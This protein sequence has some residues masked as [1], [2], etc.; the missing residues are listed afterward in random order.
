MDV[1]GVPTQKSSD[2]TT[3]I[4]IRTTRHIQIAAVVERS[5]KCVRNCAISVNVNRVSC[6]SF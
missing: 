6:S 4:H 3:P 5:R 1:T 2:V